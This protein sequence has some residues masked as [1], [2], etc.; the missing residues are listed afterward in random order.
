TPTA[1]QKLADKSA[2]ENGDE[3]DDYVQ[4]DRDSYNVDQAKK[5]DKILGARTLDEFLTGNNKFFGRPISIETNDADI[6]DVINFIADESGVNIV[7]SDDVQ[8]KISLK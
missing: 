5:E 3:G 1:D 6:R 4:A 8:G 7:V 2:T